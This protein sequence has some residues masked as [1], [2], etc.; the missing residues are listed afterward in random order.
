MGHMEASV[1]DRLRGTLWYRVPVPMFTLCFK[2]V[3]GVGLQHQAPGDRAQ[4]ANQARYRLRGRIEP[5]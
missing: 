1:L 2:S 5:G 3:L 4:V